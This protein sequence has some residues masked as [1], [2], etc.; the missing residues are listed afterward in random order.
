[1]IQVDALAV[2]SVLLLAVY[3]FAGHQSWR[4]VNIVGAQEDAIQASYR[5]GKVPWL[6]YVP[7]LLLWP[8]LLLAGQVLNAISSSATT[9]QTKR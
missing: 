8:L 5:A 6:I 4:L 2:V 1:M 9:A 3:L 7:F